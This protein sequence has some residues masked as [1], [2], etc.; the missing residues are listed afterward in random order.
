[1][2]ARKEKFFRTWPAWLTGAGLIAVIFV[3]G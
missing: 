2:Q 3:S 1:M